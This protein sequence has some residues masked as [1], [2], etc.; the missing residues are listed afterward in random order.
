[1]KYGHFNIAELKFEF[2]EWESGPGSETV[3]LLHGFPQPATAWRNVAEIMQS[4]GF[5]VIALFQRGYSRDA[6]PRKIRHYSLSYTCDDL[7]GLIDHLNVEA[8]HLV[9][10][11]WGGA[12][13]WTFASR[14]PGMVRTLTV[15]SMP[16]PGALFR[17]IFTTLQP[18][19]SWYIAIFQIPG[20][21]ELGVHVLGKQF[22]YR[23]LER[24]GLARDTARDYIDQLLSINGALTGAM[25]WY[26]ALPF[27]IRTVRQMKEIRN[28]TVF[29]WSNKD[30]AVDG[31]HA[32]MSASFVSGPYRYIEFD[33]IS[34]WIPEESP[35][36]FAQVIIEH[37]RSTSKR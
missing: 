27:N 30:V 37:A 2:V 25:N 7:R 17:A 8:V 9:G 29:V 10:H 3:I 19:K 11:D 24:T 26:R 23:W 4:N 1:M 5:R 6:I 22:I 12:V 13:A 28:S 35:N 32:K 34:H 31:T 21:I 33:G 18:I 36:E 20:L 14:H 16:H 15:A